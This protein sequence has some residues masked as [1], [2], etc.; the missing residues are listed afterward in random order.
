MAAR[1]SKEMVE[2]GE[3]GEGERTGSQPERDGAMSGV[4]PREVEEQ[5][6]VALRRVWPEKPGSWQDPREPDY[7]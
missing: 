3:Q 2:M 5:E 4:Q 1:A 6:H 7:A